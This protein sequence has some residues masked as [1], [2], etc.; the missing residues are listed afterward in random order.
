MQSAFPHGARAL[1]FTGPIKLANSRV[2]STYA[3][4]WMF[5]QFIGG[6]GA[7]HLVASLDIPLL[8]TS[9]FY[10]AVPLSRLV[11]RT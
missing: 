3:H 11:Q 10:E 9:I 8:S 7:L 4:R 1:S 6:I 2:W 5:V